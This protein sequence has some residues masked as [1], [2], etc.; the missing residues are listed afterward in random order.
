M[1]KIMNG[2]FWTVFTQETL[3]DTPESEQVFNGE[4]TEMLTGITI[5]KKIVEQEMDKLKK[6]KSP[7][8]DEMYSIV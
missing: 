3:Q 5:T 4:E 1:C 8:P 2:Y 7:W 6:L